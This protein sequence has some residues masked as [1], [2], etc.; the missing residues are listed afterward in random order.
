MIVITSVFNLVLQ[1]ALVC[2]ISEEMKAFYS[3][4]EQQHDLKNQTRE[5]RIRK[6]P[7]SDFPLLYGSIN[8]DKDKKEWNYNLKDENDLAKL[9]I[10][11]FMVCFEEITDG[12]FDLSACLNVLGKCSVFN[13]DI[14]RAAD[15]VRKVRNQWAHTNLEKWT[16]DTFAEFLDQIK[17]LI[18]KL[19]ITYQKKKSYLDE[20]DKLKDQGNQNCIC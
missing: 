11:P 18:T 1:P 16:E 2:I 3:Y 8:K 9:Y 15:A 17:D 14:R 5:N 10:Q 7:G 12:S 4:L 20:I 13:N 6:D 19:N